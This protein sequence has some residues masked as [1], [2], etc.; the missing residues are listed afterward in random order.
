[1]PDGDPVSPQVRAELVRLLEEDDWRMTTRAETDGKT[2]LLER[3]YK[4][5]TQWGICEYIL[6]K[7][8]TGF[9]LR[10]TGMGEPKGSRGIGYE[11]KNV[12]GD[13]LYIKLKIE[14]GEVWVLSFHY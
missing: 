7:L 2:I 12:D 1:M 9:P 4:Q 14:E 10:E 11:M 5:A 3:R 13:G 6:E 8:K